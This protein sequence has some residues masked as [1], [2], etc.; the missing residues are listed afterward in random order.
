MLAVLALRDVKRRALFL[1]AG[2]ALGIMALPFLPQ[3]YY[4]RMAT[5][6]SHDGDES[7]ST[8]LAVWEWTIDYATENPRGGGFDI[9]RGQQLYLSICPTR[10]GEGNTMSVE[11]ENVTDEGR[12][13]H[14]A[15]FEVLGEQGFS[16]LVMWLWLQLLGLW[17]MERIRRR[18]RDRTGEGEQWQAPLATALQYAHIIYL[19]GATVPGDRLSAFRDDAD[20]PANRA[21]RLLQAA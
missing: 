9:Y 16:D 3:S 11:Y 14:S 15:Y 12:A 10:T 18:W 7:A 6:G 4:E 20:R 2:A 21:A 13:F 1:V 19:V 5:I 17:H 8:R